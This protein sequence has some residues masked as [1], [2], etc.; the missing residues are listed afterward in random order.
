[1]NAPT[2]FNPQ[3]RRGQCADYMTNGNPDHKSKMI[4]LRLSAFEF[5]FLK[6][7][8]Q[9]YG[10][11]NVSDLARRAVQRMMQESDHLEVATNVA[12][13]TDGLE[14]LRGRVEALE[15]QAALLVET[16]RTHLVRAARELVGTAAQENT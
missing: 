10:A 3:K 13:I 6:T 2:L 15:I 4:S 8:Y 1:L 9:S 16:G 14:E 12:A 7:R 11:R 5:D